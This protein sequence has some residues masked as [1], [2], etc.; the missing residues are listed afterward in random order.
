MHPH[1]EDVI[2]SYFWSAAAASSTEFS[3]AAGLNFFAADFGAVA[4]T[5]GGNAAIAERVL[6]EIGKTVPASNF[7][8]NTLVFNVKVEKD[9]VLVTYAQ[10]ESVK[11]IKA[12][13]VVMSCPKF[14]AGHLIEGLEPERRAAYKT[15]R[16]RS[17]LLANL[18]VNKSI[19]DSFYDLFFFKEGVVDTKHVE[20]SAKKQRITD[21]VYGNYTDG[22][23][24]QTVLTLFRGYPYD[25]ARKEILAPDAYPKLRAAFEKQVNEEV[26]PLMN[27]KPSEVVD[28]RISRWGHPLPLAE[29]GTISS[30]EIRWLREPF[31]N[32][33]FFVEQDN[34]MLPCF[35]TCFMEAHHW[36]PK[37]RKYLEA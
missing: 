28:L 12:K 21:M 18:L 9:G 1:V 8:T 15:L 3:A 37:I 31:Q 25:G 13:S 24:A 36:A 32:R 22:K 6:Q 19:D 20:A 14:V 30:G 26:L 2:E 23:K 10:G 16:Y 29:K 34:W 27:I 4:V 7:R 35:E 33:V 5:K 17:Y 11:T